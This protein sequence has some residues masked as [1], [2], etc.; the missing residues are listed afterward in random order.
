MTFTGFDPAAIALL[1]RLPAMSADE[2]A[3]HKAQ[4]AEGVT[5]P[6]AALIAE[7]ADRLGADLTV[8][9]RSSVSPLHRDLR[10]APEGS[11][12]YK[13]HLLLTTWEGADKKSAPILWIRVDAR[14]AGFASGIAFDPAIRERWRAAVGSE[15]G[16]ELAELLDPL[17]CDRGAEVAGDQVKRVPPPFD[18]DHP[19]ADLL[20]R[21]GFQVRFVDDLTEAVATPDFVDW[22]VDHLDALLPVHRWLVTHLTSD[23]SD[24]AK[25]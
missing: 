7:V 2:Y 5:E 24:A 9:P 15:R 25:G 19:Q 8:V 20:R 10:F 1:D 11:A 21:T 18:A 12:R 14:R 16:A 23:T 4:L 6:G 22:C 13:D 3:D 17:M